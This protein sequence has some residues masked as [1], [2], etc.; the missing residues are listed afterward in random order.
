MTYTEALIK[1]ESKMSLIG[2]KGEKGFVI[3]D[4]IIVPQD[5]KCKNVFIQN[6]ILNRDAIQSIQPYIE[7]SV[8]IW[9][10]DTEYLDKANILFYDVLDKD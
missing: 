1:K 3:S 4:I 8:E 2:T 6:Y 10:V 7:G 5:E 9:A